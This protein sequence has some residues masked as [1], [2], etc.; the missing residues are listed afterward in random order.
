MLNSLWFF[1]II[2]SVLC[3]FATGRLGELSTAL[4]DGAQ[5]AVELSLYLLGSMC[6]WLGFLKIAEK[7]G[8]TQL[9]ARCLSPVIGRLFPEYRGDRG[10]Q[11]KIA[12]NLSANLLG[13]GNAAT[14]LGLAAMEAMAARNP[15]KER[16]P[17]GG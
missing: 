9:L 16:T 11:G 5:T 7:S 13:L 14:P 17:P 1:M 10:I 8:L 15:S 3:A 4:M 6:A 12:M 2:L